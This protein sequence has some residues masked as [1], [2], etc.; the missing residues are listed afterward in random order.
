VSLSDLLP[1]R[2]L[3]YKVVLS[4]DKVALSP[5]VQQRLDPDATELR[6]VAVMAASTTS[7]RDHA[8]FYLDATFTSYVKP[9][10]ETKPE[11]AS[12]NGQRR[13][14]GIFGLS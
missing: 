3:K 5:E 12:N 11:S 4:I 2:P 9:F 6:I 13:N 7:D 1:S 8:D 14:V 10:D